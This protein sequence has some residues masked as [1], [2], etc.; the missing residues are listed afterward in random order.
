MPNL[1]Q[2]RLAAREIFDETLQAI[3][4][5]SAVYRA[6]LRNGNQ[7]QVCGK[8]FELGNRQVYSIAIGKAAPGMAAALDEALGTRLTAG[9]IT[10]GVPARKVAGKQQARIPALPCWQ[11]FEGGHP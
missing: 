3:D 10:A 8:T 2:L 7:L 4:A 1:T 9:L 11:V 6:I 5:G